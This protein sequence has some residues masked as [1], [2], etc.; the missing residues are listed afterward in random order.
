MLVTALSPV[1]GY[2]NSAH[3]AEAALANDQSL[4]EAA[5]ASGKVTAE[6]FDKIVVP[7]SLV[8]HGVEGA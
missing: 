7:G 8:G 6:Q 5:I 2:Q 3:I 4:R 1:I